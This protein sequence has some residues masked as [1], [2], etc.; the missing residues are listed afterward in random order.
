MPQISEADYEHWRSHGY[1][2]VKVLD[3]D[4]LEAAVDNVHRYMPS[5]DEFNRDRRRYDDLKTR[6]A[7]PFVGDGLNATSVNSTLLTF[8]ER[9]LGTSRIV[10]GHSLLRGKYARTEDYE[11][12][13]HVDYQNNTLV[14]PRPDTAI[15][16][17][18]VITYYTD[19][20]V[21]L[22]PTHLVPQEHTRG[23][24]LVP[25]NLSRPQ[26]PTLYEHELPVTVAAGSTLIYSMNTWH[27]GSA[28]RAKEGA[29]YSH[30]VTFTRADMTWA[31]QETFQH[32]GGRP[33]MDH[34]IQNAT[35]RQREL[36]GF[37]PI[38][39]PYW[40]ANTLA[41]VAARYPAMDMDPYLSPS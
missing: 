9:V 36:V 12:V 3:D 30:H 18:P 34:F 33:E 27:R 19:V 23:R 1:V 5:W 38:G 35:P 31:G 8:A 32:E 20:T 41:G 29:R 28:M 13:L 25:S 15:F 40:D 17:L 6:R 10:L 22:G 37:P 24:M 26:A 14:Y 2:I 16:D 7:F 39:D 21:D 11:Q 4:Q